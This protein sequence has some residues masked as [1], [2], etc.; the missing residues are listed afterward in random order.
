MTTTE[1][2]LA[3]LE[4]EPGVRVPEDTTLRSVAGVMEDTGLSCV[5]V[6]SGPPR[7]VTEHDLAGAVAAGLPGETPVAR[8]ATREPVWATMSTTVRDAV[9]LMTGN[10]IRHLVVLD[11]RGDVA[12]VVSLLD[13][14]RWLLDPAPPAAPGGP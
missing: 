11:P 4:F 12:G 6:G 8:V 9:G 14:V 13:A 2:R 3:E 7:V 1:R 5:L 10:G